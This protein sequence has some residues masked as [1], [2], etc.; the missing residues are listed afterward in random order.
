MSVAAVTAKFD[1]Q[2][3]LSDAERTEKAMKGFVREF[4]VTA[5]IHMEA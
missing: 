5:A 3:K 4:G 2:G 1:A